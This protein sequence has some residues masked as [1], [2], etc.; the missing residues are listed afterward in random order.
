MAQLLTFHRRRI[1]INTNNSV[2]L[3]AASSA[4]SC[5]ASAPND[6]AVEI[7]LQSGIAMLKQLA[8]SP[9]A[10]A[11]LAGVNGILSTLLGQ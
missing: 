7:L 11:A 5:P 2:G 4:V 1:G 9:D 6:P 10:A 3:S 8:V